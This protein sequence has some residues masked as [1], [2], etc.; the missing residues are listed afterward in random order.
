MYKEKVTSMPD[1]IAIVDLG[2][3]TTRLVVYEYEL[4]RRFR[5]TDE[6]REVVRLREGMGNGMVLRTAAIDRTL[7]AMHT[8]AAFCAT[9]G[10]EHVVLTATS[11]VRDARNG[12]SF[13]AKVRSETGWEPRLLSGEEEGYYGALGAINGTGLRNGFVIDLGGGSA[14]V[15][16]VRNS[17]PSRR[18]S[19]P[20]GALRLSDL[21]LGF[22][23]CRPADLE[24][25]RKFLDEHLASLD[26]FKAGPDD[27]LV[28]MGGTIRNLG[29]IDQMACNYPLEGV[30]GYELPMERLASWADRLAR[31]TVG[32]AQLFGAPVAY[33]QPGDQRPG[34]GEGIGR[35]PGGGARRCGQSDRCGDGR[36]SLD[37]IT[38]LHDVSPV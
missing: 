3:N 15:V 18:A 12:E 31:M 23:R 17:L 29:K 38:T 32:L 19:L 24:R 27:R 1:R 14:Q 16:E 34:P 8:F 2:S 11:A 7:K 6:L 9:L 26:W 37:E 25:L 33:A 21:F 30:H 13:L 35:R 22:D 20:F 36:G 28:A 5:L 10:I 4:G